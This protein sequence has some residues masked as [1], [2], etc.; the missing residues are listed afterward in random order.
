M[1]LINLNNE[2]APNLNDY[3]TVVLGGSFYI[4]RIQKA[5]TNY[6]KANLSLLLQK[7]IGLFICA[8]EPEPLR[9]QELEAAFPAELFQHATA[10]DKFGYEFNFDKLKILDKILISVKGIK[11][12]I[13]ELDEE[14]IEKFAQAMS[15]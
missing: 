7:R 13:S 5:L 2:K 10:K 6:M 3:D 12:S 1:T 11:K 4:G 9:S 14:A 8:G 15:I